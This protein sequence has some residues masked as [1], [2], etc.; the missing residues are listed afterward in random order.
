MEEKENSKLDELLNH[1][2]EYFKTR[3]ELSKLIAI[4][5]TSVANR[6]AI[7]YSRLI[8]KERFSWLVD[9]HS[10][11]TSVEINFIRRKISIVGSYL[12]IEVVNII[13]I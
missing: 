10:R 1:G 6:Y 11:K 5:K 3:Q 7:I 13:V 4:E 2:E 8:V 12:Q 9:M